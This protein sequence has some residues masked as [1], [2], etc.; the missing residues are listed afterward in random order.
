MSAG[1]LSADAEGRAARPRPWP[2]GPRRGPQMNVSSMLGFLSR[3]VDSNDRSSGRSNPRREDNELSRD[4]GALP[5]KSCAPSSRDSRGDS[6]AGAPRSRRKTSAITRN[7]S[8]VARSAGTGSSASTRPSR[9][10]WKG[11]ARGLRR[12]REAMQRTLGMRISTSRWSRIVL[13]QGRIAEMKTGEGKTCRAA[14]R[15]LNA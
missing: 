5:T 13:H 4:A 10:P 11:P 6:R 2:F 9:T 8:A 12:A 1:F 7:S 3:F 14:R 15:A